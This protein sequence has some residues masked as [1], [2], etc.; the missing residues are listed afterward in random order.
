[1]NQFTP[2]CQ[3]LEAFPGAKSP[4]S[5]IIALDFYDGPTSGITQCEICSSVYR[6]VML[7]WDD[8]Q[9][10]RIFSLVPLPSQ[11]WIQVANLLSKHE[12]PNWPMWFPRWEIPS[13]AVRNSV[14]DETDKILES[15]AMPEFAV[16]WD[17]YGSKVLAAKRLKKED[18]KFIKDWFSLE[19]SDCVRDWF[20]FLGLEKYEVV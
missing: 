20:S 14:D 18:L 9:E 16:A 4:F 1:M 13:E 15:A 11:S 8:D 3:Q 5:K 7:D 10:V 12:T 6:F 2:C 19:P 17:R